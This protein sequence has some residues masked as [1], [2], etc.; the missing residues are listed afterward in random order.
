M[1]RRNYLPA[2]SPVLDPNSVLQD[3]ATEKLAASNSAAWRDWIDW[4]NSRKRA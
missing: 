4:R 2:F 1:R 3:E